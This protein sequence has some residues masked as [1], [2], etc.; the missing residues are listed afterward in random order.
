MESA[1]EANAGSVNGGSQSS[2]ESERSSGI[3]CGA[4]S[5]NVESDHG[6]WIH[7]RD[8]HVHK[9]R[10]AI[11]AT[12]I[13]TTLAVCIAIYVSVTRGDYRSFK[14]EVSYRNPGATDVPADVRMRSSRKPSTSLTSASF[15]HCI[16]SV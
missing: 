4:N 7:L 8:L 11:A 6:K 14:L 10:F 9:A 5:G 15:D 3:A 2:D 1:D 12:V 13:T 16:P